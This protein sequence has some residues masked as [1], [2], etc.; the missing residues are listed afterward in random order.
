MAEK[1]LS[2]KLIAKLSV[3]FTLLLLIMGA[4]Y[5]V[6]SI[7][8]TNKYFDET[9]QRLNASLADHLIEEKFQNASPFLEDGSVNKELF[10]GP[11][12]RHDGRKP[13]Y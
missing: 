1:T 12:A 7:Y 10:G 11:D 3:T 13:K 2:N 6:T 9:S 5:I 8:F 4:A